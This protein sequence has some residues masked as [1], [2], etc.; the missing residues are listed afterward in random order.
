[1]VFLF[2]FDEL[3]ELGSAGGAVCVPS[4]DEA[5]GCA[6]LPEVDVLFAASL[7][8]VG[9]SGGAGACAAEEPGGGVAAAG[10][11]SFFRSEVASLLVVPV[12]ARHQRAS[13]TGRGSCG[14]RRISSSRSR[15][16]AGGR[17]PA[18]VV[19]VEA[20][21]SVVPGAASERGTGALASGAPFPP[22]AA[23]RLRFL[24]SPYPTLRE[25][26]C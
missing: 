16:R 4:A 23:A 18:A 15:S 22:V 20:A 12:A 24:S 19:A 2:F 26:R 1:M 7:T 25:R 6:V 21:A 9:G 13:R 17:S 3:S 11:R 5:A 10:D 8:C 14:R